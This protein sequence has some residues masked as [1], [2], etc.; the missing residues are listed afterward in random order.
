[1]VL[2][3]L[4]LAAAQCSQNKIETCAGVGLITASTGTTPRAALDA[5]LGEQG[6]D[7]TEWQEAG[8]TAFERTAGSGEPSLSSISV[9]RRPDGTWSVSGGCR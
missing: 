7:P 8:D 1:M 4:L 9:R 5:Y 2:P 6:G 3:V